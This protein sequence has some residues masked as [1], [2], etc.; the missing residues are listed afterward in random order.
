MP[1]EHRR[2]SDKVF[3]ILEAGAYLPHND[4]NDER[5]DVMNKI[6]LVTGSSRGLGRNAALSIARHGGDVIVTYHSGEAEALAVVNEIKGMGRK[7]VAL[8]L[9]VGQVDT[10]EAFAEK[11]REALEETWN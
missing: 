9:D 4:L 7:A 2:L 1:H 10:F 5:N 8:R 3:L 11:V 6:A